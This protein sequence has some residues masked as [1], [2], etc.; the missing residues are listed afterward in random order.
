MKIDGYRFIGV[1]FT[2]W[3]TFGW[4]EDGDGF[5]IL[6]VGPLGFVFAEEMKMKRIV[7][8]ADGTF[9]VQECSVSGN[10]IPAAYHRFQTEAE[11]R[12]F[13]SSQT[14]KRIIEL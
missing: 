14:Q 4:R 7:E 9:E 10:W 1:H 5:K 2:W 12:R 3:L 8:F 6:F 11:A 13:A